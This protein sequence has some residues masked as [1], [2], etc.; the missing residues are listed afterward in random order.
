[1]RRTAKQ[2]ASSD[3]PAQ[4]EIRILANLGS[5]KRFA[6]LRGRWGRAWRR[7]QR[8]AKLEDDEEKEKAAKSTGLGLVAAYSD[9]ED[10]EGADSPTQAQEARRARLKEWSAKRREA[11]EGQQLD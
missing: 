9:S 5:D 10:E 6:F 1:M 4:L 2:L 3:N 11:R 7:I 8:T